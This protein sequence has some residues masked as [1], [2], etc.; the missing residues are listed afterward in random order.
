MGDTPSKPKHDRPA[1]PIEVGEDGTI[2]QGEE[3]Y[4]SSS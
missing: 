2:T 1:P 3:T 4:G